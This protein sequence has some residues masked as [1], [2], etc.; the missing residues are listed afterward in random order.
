MP[1]TPDLTPDELATYEWQMWLPGLGAPQQRQLKGASVLISRC[2]GV[3]GLVAYE[4]AAAG[5]GRLVIAHAG[6]IKP[7]DLHRQL[8]MTHD[9]LGSPRIDSIVRKL[10]ELNPRV[11]I[12]AVS[13]NVSD[14]NVRRLVEQVDIVVDAAPLF[15]ERYAMND[16]AVRQNKPMVECAMYAME[17]SVTT[18]LPGRGPCLRCL[19]P[20]PPPT[21]TRRFPVLGAVSGA[22]GCLGAVEVVKLITGLGEPLV[23]RMLR[24]DLGAMTSRVYRTFR[25]P[26]CAACGGK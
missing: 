17:L 11:E 3:G 6:N 10:R 23:G 26:Q 7:S 14:A 12:V 21:W 19:V 18:V 25:D 8:L 15:E 2:G 9:A 5:V 22:A 13:E 1:S 16:E 20:Q 24:M 4:L